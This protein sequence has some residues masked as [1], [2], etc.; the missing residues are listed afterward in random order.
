MK[1]L[2]YISLFI[3]SSLTLSIKGECEQCKLL[4]EETRKLWSELRAFSKL[5]M[6][7]SKANCDHSKT[8]QSLRSGS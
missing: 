4:Q 7:Q 5:I 2:L 6:E 8:I 1:R 3:M